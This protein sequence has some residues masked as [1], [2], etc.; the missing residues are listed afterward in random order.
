MTANHLC[1]LSKLM[2]IS[3]LLCLIS[4]R[5]IEND[6]PQSRLH[7]KIS[8]A[9]SVFSEK[10]SLTSNASQMQGRLQQDST[11]DGYVPLEVGFT[12]T[13]K[14]LKLD[15]FLVGLNLA[16]FYQYSDVCFDSLIYTLDDWAYFRNNITLFQR[17]DNQS[18]LSPFLNIT[19][20]I[21]DNFA[22]SI[23]NCYQFIDSINTVESARWIKFNKSWLNLILAFLFN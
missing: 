6:S 12:N 19:G 15:S 11:Y 23:P 22:D 7:Q 9:E 18:L 2:M 1:V 8:P 20:L 3:L 5:A 4:S 21:G 17:Y 10:F 14:Y 13:D 16:A